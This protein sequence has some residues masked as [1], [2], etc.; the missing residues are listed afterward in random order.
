MDYK[1]M[2]EQYEDQKSA[3][4][5][6]RELMQNHTPRDNIDS[7]SS[8]VM[9]DIDITLSGIKIGK[10]PHELRIEAEANP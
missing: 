2:L 1:E 4:L 8:E 6:C 3:Y 5:V 9:K 7:D 10:F